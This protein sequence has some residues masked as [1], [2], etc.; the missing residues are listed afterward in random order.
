MCCVEVLS[1][2]QQMAHVLCG[3]VVWR[4]AD[5]SCVVWRCFV[6]CSRWLMCCVEVFC[7]VQ[8]MAHVL[9]GVQ[10]SGKML[11]LWKL[12]HECDIRSPTSLSALKLLAYQAFSS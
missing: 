3:G 2:V 11:V 5:G 4:A 6:A 10:Y 1:G 9:C 12:I 8:Q 7:G